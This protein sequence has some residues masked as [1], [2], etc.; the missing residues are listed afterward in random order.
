MRTKKYK[1]NEYI[2]AEGVWVR[3]PYKDADP[4]D[5]N[6]LSNNEM[7]LFLRNETKN[8]SAKD[9]KTDSMD[10]V[11][12]EN[13]II[14]SDGYMWKERQTVLAEIP[15]K[16]VKVI[17]VNGSLAGWRMVGDLSD[18]KRVMSFYL[19]NNPYGECT[20]YLPRAHKYYPSLV[21][22]AKTCPEFISSYQER[23]VFYKATRDSRYSGLPRDGC[24][25]L[26]DYRNPV[27]AAISLCVK[28]GV[29]RLA[30]LCCDESF[31]DERPAATRMKNG[32]YQ[33]PQQIKSQRIIDRQLY[34]LRRNGVE[35]ADCSSGEEYENATYI[36]PEDLAS[37]FGST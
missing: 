10:E 7:E 19:V 24:M 15:N 13:A 37:F 11:Q 18:K 4:V 32:M 36:K 30:L 20:S 14:C 25:V 21:A 26:D 31:P 8:I 5:I 35:V 33:Y 27:C 17:G 23:P 3:N 1:N 12:I 6:D 29:K 16:K 28:R 9:I 34:W 22:S 2:L